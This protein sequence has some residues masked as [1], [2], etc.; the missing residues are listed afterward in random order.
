MP[1]LALFCLIPDRVGSK[2]DRQNAWISLITRIPAPRLRRELSKFV[3]RPLQAVITNIKLT[4][5]SAA[6]HVSR[7]RERW[8]EGIF[9]NL[10][11]SDLQ[12]ILALTPL[13]GE[14]QGD[15]SAGSKH[16][17]HRMRLFAG[18][19]AMCLA[20]VLVGCSDDTTS[21]KDTAVP[22]PLE[23]AR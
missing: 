23:A 16:G 14:A 10:W 5:I 8:K 9:S 3:P 19:F 15:P 22:P 7:S 11:T 18:I 13:G 12:G 20:V 4:R 17:V 6:C 2:R 21:K 1:A